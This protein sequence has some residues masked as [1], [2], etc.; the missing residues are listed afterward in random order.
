MATGFS[1]S[2]AL[3]HDTERNSCEEDATEHLTIFHV[4]GMAHS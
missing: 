3:T 4:A 2:D 1:A